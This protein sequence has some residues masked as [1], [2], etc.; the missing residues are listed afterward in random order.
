MTKGAAV[1]GTT[2][3]I[4]QLGALQAVDAGI[5]ALTDELERLPRNLAA[6]K[7]DQAAVQEKLDRAQEERDELL[8]K[9]RALEQEIQAADQN[10]IKYENDKIKV[11]TN[12]EF[13]AL[14]N[15][16]EKEKEKKSELEDAVLLSYEDEEKVAVV[17][18]RLTEELGGVSQAVAQREKELNE[19]A[20]EDAKRL[21]ELKTR[22]EEILKTFD[23]KVH[24]KYENIRRSKG[25]T[26]VVPIMRGACGGCHTQQPPQKVNEVRKKLALQ[27][28]E[29]CGRFLIWSDLE[30]ATA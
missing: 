27:H 16:I 29:F 23:P 24:A 6:A 14:N 19:R 4:E 7:Q 15:Q 2:E 20:A 3:T 13:R 17:V 5:Q 28:C 18:N 8:K 30:E 1:V 12:E 9:R 21:E 25:A 22:R 26:A 10:V 11:K